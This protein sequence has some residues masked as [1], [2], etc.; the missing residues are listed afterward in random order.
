MWTRMSEQQLS[1][2]STRAHR[3]AKRLAKKEGRT[4]RQIVEQALD[5]YAA[6]VLAAKE[7]ETD[8]A[9]WERINRD[10]ATDIDLQALID[11]NRKP[12]KPIDL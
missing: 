4:V 11:E 7:T 9:F 2:R 1:I 10:Y 8:A 6:K 12:H 5:A 3:I